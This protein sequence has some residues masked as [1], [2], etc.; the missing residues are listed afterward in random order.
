MVILALSKLQIIFS[1][2]DFSL[3]S[4]LLT[5]ARPLYRVRWCYQNISGL[6]TSCTLCSNGR[7]EDQLMRESGCDD[8][9]GGV[10]PKRDSICGD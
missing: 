8:L 9:S 4:R 3:H 5:S 1:V 6:I 10:W 7:L 2:F